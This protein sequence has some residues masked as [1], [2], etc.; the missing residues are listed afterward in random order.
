MRSIVL[1]AVLVSVLTP[2]SFA[3]AQAV[4]GESAPAAS[5]EGRRPPVA[6]EEIVVTARKREERIQDV[7]I[8][9]TAFTS[10]AL[11]G[12]SITRNEFIGFASPNVQFDT[13]ADQQDTARIFIRGV[14]Q[15]NVLFSSD[16]G[17][18][19]YVDGVYLSRQNGGIFDLLDIERVE[20]LRG[21]QGTLFGKNTPGGA[22]QVITNK[23]SGTFESMVQG[24]LGNDDHVSGR[25]MVNV[26]LVDETLF[27][28]IAMLSTSTDG[29]MTNVV[30][31]SK[32]QGDKG[33]AG[34]A[35]LRWLP[36]DDVDAVLSFEQT[37]SHEKGILN[38]CEWDPSP[39]S[40]AP[41]G[42]G[43]FT[44]Q[45]LDSLLGTSLF[46]DFMAACISAD[47]LAPDHGASDTPSV[48]HS[49]TWQTTGTVNWD[50]DWANL[51][52][53]SSWRTTEVQRSLAVD[54]TSFPLLEVDS[55]RAGN[56]APSNHKQ[57]SQEFQLSG[58]GLDGRLTWLGGAYGLI[59]RA[60]V[61]SGTCLLPQLAFVGGCSGA[62]S[63]AE[64]K[65]WTY[66]FFGEATY[67]VTERLA[68][69]AGLRRSL[70]RKETTGSTS[71]GVPVSFN[72]RFSAWTPRAI[73]SFHVTEDL[74]LYGG[75]S[76]GFKSGGLNNVN[77]PPFAP[78]FVNVWEAGFK[79]TSFDDRLTVNFSYFYNDYQDIQLSVLR[80]NGAGSFINQI[81]NAGQA[82]VKGLELEI[83]ARP[84]EG[85]LLSG[86]LGTIDAQYDQFDDIEPSTGL[87][88]DR[89]NLDFV[90]TPEVTFN[91]SAEYG[92]PVGDWGTLTARA[93]WYHQGNVHNDTKNTPAID[94]GK[95]G[96]LNA[97]L[98]FR[99]PDQRT[100]IA[101][102]GRNL[103][104]RR[105]FM[106][107]ATL[108]ESFGFNF[109]VWSP[110]RRYG[111]E[112]TRYF[113]G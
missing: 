112:I 20:V 13:A 33:I 40:L 39:E 37:K 62:V 22:I 16:P 64:L 101:L 24:G 26:P 48:S 15:I 65:N 99:L 19:L 8:S 1:T 84:V 49:D 74:M 86:G 11:E 10:A 90:L 41:P 92:L 57:W 111:I 29:Y 72:D 107:A 63:K 81:T 17:V 21:P 67:D 4:P 54:G 87:Q 61:Q 45:Y 106:M 83:A 104:D 93:D 97:R 80:S 9:M 55:S 14:G 6:R 30:D 94:Q 73:A 100:E 113:G 53:I 89:S 102:W 95:V 69:T 56:P 77:V 34:R 59:E 78:E 110:P 43:L 36:T 7:P 46:N 51:K 71:A 52:S 58:T 18:G 44:L 66:A 75:W 31:G 76:R 27:A 70:E 38:L 28:R 12:R 42:G 103:L 68:L 109:E 82:T 105:Y 98:S 79:S 91:L 25:F 32:Y 85:L 50:L 23:P 60:R 5:E 3:F 35:S 2:G 88:V 96:L 47:A 108:R